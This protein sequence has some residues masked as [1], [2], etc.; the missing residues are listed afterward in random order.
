M[1]FIVIGI[2]YRF[3][4]IV[5]IKMNDAPNFFKPVY[6]HSFRYGP[7]AKFSMPIGSN[8]WVL[9]ED[10]YLHIFTYFKVSYTIRT[11]WLLLNGV[12]VRFFSY[13][14]D[15]IQSEIIGEELKRRF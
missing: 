10:Q 15:E 1:K 8:V 13:I 4:L 7:K 12:S 14:A 6:R 9:V 11:I 5:V 3:V 2:V